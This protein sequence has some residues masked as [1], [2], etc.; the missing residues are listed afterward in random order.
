M[1]TNELSHWWKQL[2]PIKIPNDWSYMSQLGFI[3][4][5]LETSCPNLNYILRHHTRTIHG[6]EQMIKCRSLIVFE[7]I[8]EIASGYNHLEIGPYIDAF[9]YAYLCVDDYI[10]SHTD[11]SK[12][13]E[14]CHERINHPVK[15]YDNQ[16]SKFNDIMK[17]LD[18]TID[19]QTREKLSQLLEAIPNTAT[20]DTILEHNAN[21]GVLS[22][23]LMIKMIEI[24]LGPSPKPLSQLIK[25][26]LG[27]II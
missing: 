13:I 1:N 21:K 4:H 9:N 10:D 5:V 18:A 6:P 7:L 14:Y 17:T 25:S 26:K 20:Q 2:E 19:N 24:D 3:G 12:F 22:F 16:T 8:L 11:T 27:F 23:D 15:P